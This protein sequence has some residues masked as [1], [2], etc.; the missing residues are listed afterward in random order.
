M[1]TGTCPAGTRPRLRL[2]ELPVNI[3]FA[4]Q[5]VREYDADADEQEEEENDLDD[6]TE[7]VTD[8][9]TSTADES[10]RHRMP[11]PKLSKAEARAMKKAV[12]AAKS[13]VKAAKNQ[14]RHVINVRSEDVTFVTQVLHG[15]AV[16]ADGSARATHPL[17]T[18]KTIEE[19]IA[20]N[21]GFLSSIDEHKRMLLSSI[22]QR[23]RSDRD[24]RKSS[25]AT[26]TSSS[27][28]KRR[29]SEDVHDD[30]AE[31]EELEHLLVAAM[32]KLGVDAEHARSAD[33]IAI[34]NI[35]AKKSGAG[36]TR[37]LAICSSNQT[38]SIVS[39]L[40]ALVR[41]DLERFDNEQRE[42]CIRAGG[43]WRYVGR[44]VFERM[45]A[46]AREV[47]WKTGMKLKEVNNNKDRED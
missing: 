25:T 28:R 1:T 43:F 24:R 36:A 46:V 39:N 7:T 34:N 2:E 17:A 16:D 20:R 3:P 22:A 12:K 13:L 6:D 40:K 21:M 38:L 5:A 37:A 8:T 41:D 26:S 10:E 19:V 14:K 9:T 33:T 32:V 15:E 23:R 31:D 11:P 18:D 30:N 47:D 45:T 27:G 4:N 44:P 29:F 35:G 42:T